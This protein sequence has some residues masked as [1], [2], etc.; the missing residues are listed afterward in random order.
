M[1]GSADGKRLVSRTR[2]NNNM[3]SPLPQPQHSSTDRISAAPPAPSPQR[4]LTFLHSN[5]V[6]PGPQQVVPELG[7][8]ALWGHHRRPTSQ[9]VLEPR[10]IRVARQVQQQLVAAVVCQ[11]D[12]AGA[13]L[14][15]GPVDQLRGGGG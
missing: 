9:Q 14:S 1:L 4:L 2:P 15:R 5:E 10:C 8:A 3:P 13:L 6:L 12:E 7:P 11:G